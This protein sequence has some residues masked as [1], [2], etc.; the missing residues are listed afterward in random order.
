MHTCEISCHV[1]STMMLDVPYAYRVTLLLH[2]AF[3]QLAAGVVQV[4]Q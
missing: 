1:P 3:C 4:R 2:S